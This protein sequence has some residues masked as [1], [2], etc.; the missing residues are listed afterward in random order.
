MSAAKPARPKPS[1]SSLR[2]AL[3]D[4]VDD[5]AR[6][7]QLGRRLVAAVAVLAIAFTAFY[8]YDRYYT[9]VESPLEQ[10]VHEL[11]NKVRQQ[12][13]DVELRL[14]VAGGYFR[15][16]RYDEAIK[17]YTEALKLRENWQ[18]A[19][20]G[21]AS[22]ELARGNEAKTEEI[23]RTIVELNKDNEMKYANRDLGV[24]FYRLGAFAEKKKNYAEAADW[25]KEALKIDRGDADS[26]FLLAKSEETLGNKEVAR[27]A[28]RLATDFD[29]NFREGF[30]GLSR[31]AS[32]L[33]DQREASYAH[34]MEQLAAGDADAALATFRQLVQQAPDFAEA[35]QGLGLALG[36]KGQREEAERAFRAALER[37]PS[38]LLAQWSLPSAQPA[39]APA[40]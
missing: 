17:Q 1:I 26:L 8:V 18:P 33:G 21:I 7:A 5:D 31:M 34:G 20:L 38:L 15:Q 10:A 13:N 2:Q 32:A 14:Q 3:A 36:K 35:H 28:Y 40:K 25:A 16:K 9:T 30:A 37:K 39:G 12:P 19:L 29:P 4:L 22:S 27:E 24:V 6:L 11:E 23:Y